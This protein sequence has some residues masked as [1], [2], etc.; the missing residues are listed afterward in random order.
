MVSYPFTLWRDT[1]ENF[2]KA[3]TTNTPHYAVFVVN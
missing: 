1:E 3:S 2:S